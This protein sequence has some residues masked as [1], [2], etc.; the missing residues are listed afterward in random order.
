MSKTNKQRKE[1]RKTNLKM[2]QTL[3]YMRSL[4]SEDLAEWSEKLNGDEKE[5]QEWLENKYMI[6][7]KS[8]CEECANNSKCLKNKLKVKSCK[9]FVQHITKGDEENE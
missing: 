6:S 7:N 4:K 9:S 2:A 8:L 3:K 5:L 1:E